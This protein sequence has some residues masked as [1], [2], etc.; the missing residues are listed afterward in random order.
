[1]KAWGWW[2]AWVVLAGYRAFQV[3]LMCIGGNWLGWVL[4]LPEALA[5]GFG[6]A[7]AW[8]AERR[9]S[10]AVGLV[11]PCC[12]AVGIGLLAGASVQ[13]SA[14]ATSLFLLAELI[15][16]W[17]L[18]CLGT[19]F[20]VASSAWVSL[21]DQGPYRLVRHPQLLA[22]IVIV[23]ACTVPVGDWWRLLACVALTV[24]VI[25]VEEGFLME[26][27]EYVGY[28]VRVPYRLIPGVF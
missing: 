2:I 26:D 6:V 11:V 22:R 25:L 20:S 9:D 24:T 28:T 13:T 12:Y 4:L 10:R 23:I 16:V 3:L 15:S 17:A 7:N 1:M 21:C 18:V 8:K 5:L 19:R 27:G 14:V